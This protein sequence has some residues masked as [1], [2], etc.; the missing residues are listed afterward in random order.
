MF[1]DEAGEFHE[2]VVV[3][4]LHCERAYPMAEMVQAGDLWWCKHYPECEG[5]MLD[6]KPWSWVRGF[7]SQYPEVPIAG[8]V[9]PLYGNGGASEE[10]VQVEGRNDR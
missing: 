5:G 2:K 10:D 7:N 4:C 9:Y 1:A 3:W 6:I 8:E